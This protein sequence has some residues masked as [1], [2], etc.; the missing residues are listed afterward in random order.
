VLNYENSLS[1]NQFLIIE[2]YF[3]YTWFHGRICH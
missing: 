3:S 2:A 1:S